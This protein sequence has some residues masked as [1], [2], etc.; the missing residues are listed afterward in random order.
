MSSVAYDVVLSNASK[1]KLLVTVTSQNLTLRTDPVTSDSKGSVS[2]KDKAN[3]EGQKKDKD[4]ESSRTGRNMFKAAAEGKRE[5]STHRKDRR[6]VESSGENKRCMCPIGNLT[7]VESITCIGASKTVVRVP[8]Y[9][10]AQVGIANPADEHVFVHVKVD[11]KH[12]ETGALIAGP[13]KFDLREGQKIVRIILTANKEL[14]R[15]S[16]ADMWIEEDTGIDHNPGI[17]RLV[18]AGERC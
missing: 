2:G 1:L 6:R 4:K 16:Q 14:V 9:G 10:S 12:A 18:G 5:V 3:G 13:E 15:A 11:T 7:D 8:K 17:S